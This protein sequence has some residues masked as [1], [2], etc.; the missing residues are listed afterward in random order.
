MSFNTPVRIHFLTLLRFRALWIASVFL[1]L[2]GCQ[3]SPWKRELFE[4]GNAGTAVYLEVK[5]DVDG[6]EED[7]GYA[8]P[9]ELSESEVSGFL[10]SLRYVKDQFLSER[11]EGALFTAEEIGRVV[12]SVVRALAEVGPNQRVRFVVMRTNR[13]FSVFQSVD[14]T[15]GVVFKTAPDEIHFAF[16]YLHE[17]LAEDSMDPREVSLHREPTEVVDASYTLVPPEGVS[18]HTGQGGVRHPRWVTVDPVRVQASAASIPGVVETPKT[19]ASPSASKNLATPSP[20]VA[21]EPE[22]SVSNAVRTITEFRGYAI[23]Q[24]GDTFYGLPRAND[25]AKPGD[26]G[27]FSGD[28]AGAVVNAIL[29]AE[30]SGKP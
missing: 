30:K 7:L 8:H 13:H 23:V 2:V 18:H 12:P 26:A 20:A 11:F 22:S 10:S 9:I 29:E 15:S 16:D 25:K 24:V 14:C 28:S 3:V 6:L 27:V 19:I 17:E 5:H 1:G 4:P 21:S